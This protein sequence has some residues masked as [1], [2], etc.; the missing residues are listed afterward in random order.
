MPSPPD[1]LAGLSLGQ[2]T[3]AHLAGCLSFA[4]AV[5]M[6]HTMATLEADEFD[7]TDYGV[8]FFSNV[9]LERLL[10]VADDLDAQGHYLRPC[11]FIADDQII[12]NGRRDGL[13]RLAQAAFALGGAGVMIPYGPPAHCALMAGVRHQFESRWAPRDSVHDP[14]TPLICNLTAQPLHSGEAVRAA[15]AAQ[16][17]TPVRWVHSMRRLAALGVRQVMVPGPGAFLARSLRSTSVPF[18]VRLGPGADTAAPASAGAR[19]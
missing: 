6:A 11:A 15:L 2:I 13:A 14:H 4:D 8:A 16:Y 17:T 1:Y 5:R 12:M 18:E 9:D 7:G 10:A 3:A 19:S